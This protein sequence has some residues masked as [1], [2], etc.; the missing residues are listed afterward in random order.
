MNLK[1]WFESLDK[2]T[3]IVI[4][5]FIIGFLLRFFISYFVFPAGDSQWHLSVA[6]FIART[7][8]IPLFEPLGRA[9]FWVPPLYHIC[10]AIFYKIFSIIGQ[11][12][13]T[14]SMNFVSPIF[15]SLSLVVMYLFAKKMF[16]K[17]VALFSLI[18]LTFIPIHIYYSTLQHLDITITF[19]VLLTVY[20]LY[21]KHLYLGAIAAGLGTLTKYTVFFMFPLFM[22]LIYWNNRDSKR[23]FKNTIKHLLIFFLIIAIIGAPWYIRNIT[24]VGTPFYPILNTF[25]EKIGFT[26]IIELEYKLQ[27]S[28]S[29]LFRPTLPFE[30]YLDMFGVPLG[31]PSNLLYLDVPF[32]PLF[33]GVWLAITVLFF[34]PII[35]GLIVKKNSQ[36]K[37]MLWLWIV[38]IFV[39]LSISELLEYGQ[40]FL[41]YF[42]PIFPA[43]ALLWALGFG[44]IIELLK[45]KRAKIFIYVLLIGCIIT[46]SF[47]EIVKV[48]V[49]AGTHAKYVED[50]EWAKQN[51]PKSALL[52]PASR[53]LILNIDRLG[54]PRDELKEYFPYN[55]SDVYY[56]YDERF[57]YDDFGELRLNLTK[58]QLNHELIYENNKTGVKIFK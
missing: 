42:L 44:K 2:E 14:K 33:I 48:K 1:Q 58:L 27:P 25:F 22:F 38:P 17:R 36:L 53:S 39:L 35:F 34:I 31:I 43:V 49:A 54:V 16:N 30:F 5:V 40:L 23:I 6:R 28:L 52:Y 32:F 10:A 45:T 4:M 56:W 20:F 19:F 26:P 15:G 12:A 50:Y 11:G 46:F 13:A 24:T 57:L 9:T 7:G 3:K 21:T 47:G 8:E 41:R 37:Y 29:N 55:E 51:L 18:F